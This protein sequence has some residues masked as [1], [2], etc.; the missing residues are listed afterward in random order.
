MDLDIRVDGRV[1]ANV[2]R[3]MD[4]HTDGWTEN[5]IPIS[6]HV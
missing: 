3:W 5:R 6:H 1:G 4:G 2:D